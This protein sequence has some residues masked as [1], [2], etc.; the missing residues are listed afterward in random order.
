[1]TRPE[2]LQHLLDV[3]LPAM[4]ARAHDGDSPAS[5]ARITE[6][7]RT[8]GNPGATPA[9]LPV[10]NW[11]DRALAREPDASDLAALF[12]AFRTLSPLLHWRTRTGDSTAS[13]GFADNHANAMLLGP[14]GLEERRDLWLG[15][16][17]LAPGTRYPDH[18]HAPE[19][20]Y[21]VLS[22]GQFRRNGSDWFEPGVGGS[23][24]VAPNSV[25]AMRAT[26]DAPLFAL[27]ALWA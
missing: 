15:I 21:L 20:T 13:E 27:W 3:A 5:L 7:S 10:C 9:S 12:A 2:P 24:F 8:V 19:E 1:M 14:G 4:Q 6:A 18:Q 23:F 26:K 11:L 17:L 22:P 16:S 25:H